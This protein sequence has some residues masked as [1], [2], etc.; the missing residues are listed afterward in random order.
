M[1]LKIKIINV[2][3]IGWQRMTALGLFETVL[4]ICSDRVKEPLE[5]NLLP[6]AITGKYNA[7]DKNKCVET[8][9]EL[10]STSVK[11]RSSY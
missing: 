1:I 4:S 5:L 9:L 2:I 8:R 6:K 7:T 11:N 3:T 10:F